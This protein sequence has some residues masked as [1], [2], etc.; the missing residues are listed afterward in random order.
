MLLIYKKYAGDATFG[1]VKHILLFNC[2]IMKYFFF[3][4]LFCTSTV[5]AA[6]VDTIQVFSAAMQKNVP[7]VVVKPD[8]KK[9]KK[10][11]YPVV[12]LLHG[13][14]GNYSSW[15]KDF[16]S[17]TTDADKYGIIVVC[18]DGGFSSWY[19]D[20]PLDSSYRYET[21]MIN[22]LLPYIDA[23]Y[24]TIADRAHRGISGLSMGGHGAFYLTLRHKDLFG[25]VNSTSGG[26]DIRPFPN[27]WD[28]KK[29]LG[30][31][32]SYPQNWEAHTVI[33]L[34]DSLKKGE[35]K[36][37]FDCGVSDFFLQVNR[38]LHKKLLDNKIA[39]D[40]TERPGGH[41]GAY[42][43]TAILYHMLFF[44]NFFTDPTL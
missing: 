5:F 12:Y 38:D 43:R 39:H 29:R 22:E 44:Y 26:V 34:A 11:R 18:P 1:N 32:T 37:A 30:E 16:P 10:E 8:Q 3:L 31:I 36:I 42:W 28:I 23:N 33:N 27:N 41:N 20:S 35:L 19:L 6:K 21:F 4:V 7:C 9:S 24:P 25:V 17:V 14:S 15:V 13:Y 2:H 40:Y